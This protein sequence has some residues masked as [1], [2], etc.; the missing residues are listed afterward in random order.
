MYMTIISTTTTTFTT[1]M[2]VLMID[3]RAMGFDL[4]LCMREIMHS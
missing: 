3:L 2:S 4:H 1:I